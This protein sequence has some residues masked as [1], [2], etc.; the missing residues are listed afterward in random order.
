MEFIYITLLVFSA[1]SLVISIFILIRSLSNNTQQKITEEND[2]LKSIISQENRELR[3]EINATL[4][5]YNNA[6]NNTVNQQILLLQ[7]QMKEFSQAQRDFSQEQKNELENMRRSMEN[8]LRSIQEDNAQKLEK[9]RE[10]VDEKL[11]ST[12][13]KRL[14]ESFATVGNQLES[15]YKGLGEMQTLASS[16]GDLKSALTNVK[17]RGTW[18]EVSLDSL[19]SQI[20]SPEQYKRNVKP[21][22]RKSSIVEFCICLPNNE[23][24]DIVYLPIDCKFPIEDYIRLCDASETGDLALVE[25]ASKNLENAIKLCARTIRDKYI[26]PPHTTDF[27]IMYLP[28]EGLYA[29]VARKSGLC[30]QLQREYRVTVAGPTT[31]GAFLNSLQLGFKTLAIQKRT[32]QIT[33]LLFDIKKNFGHFADL[34]DKTKKKLDEASA[35]INDATSRYQRI[36][37]L[38]GKADTFSVDENPVLEISNVDEDNI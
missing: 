32:S 11:S 29:E 30:E 2:A 13:E 8:N 31:I 22:P 16:V 7:N 34:L 12:L 23:N 36:D 3:K 24:N 28:I 10:T 21:N 5:S 27:A 19:L 6:V 20:L 38:L 33:K 15:V 37:T 4:S 1:I 26:D 18:G 25:S 9:M 14:T 17:V 35:K